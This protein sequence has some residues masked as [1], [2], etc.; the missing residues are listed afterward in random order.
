MKEYKHDSFGRVCTL[1]GKPILRARHLLTNKLQ[2]RLV[3]GTGR[4]FFKD[5]SKY[6]LV[7]CGSC[8]ECVA[9]TQD[10]YVQRAQS[11]SLYNY[12]FF[13]TLTFDDAHLPRLRVKV[14]PVAEESCECLCPYPSIDLEY[15]PEVTS[16]YSDNV[17]DTVCDNFDSRDH[18]GDEFLDLSDFPVEPDPSDMTGYRNRVV[19]RDLS[20]ILEE[21][22]I[23]DD[24][25]DMTSIPYADVHLL[26]LLMKRIRDN[27]MTLPEFAGRSMRYLA[28]SELGKERGR[29]H[30][31]IK[32]SVSKLASDFKNGSV[33]P[34]ARRSLINPG[35][36]ENME[37]ILFEKFQEYWA[38][39]VG[40][41]KNP[42]Y[43]RLFTYRQKYKNG[44]LFRNFDCHFVDPENARK[45]AGTDD[46]SYY[47]TKYAL[48]DSSW[49]QKR[50]AFLFARFS[51]KEAREYYQTIRSRLLISKGYG[52]NVTFVRPASGGRRSMI[53][54]REL[55]ERIKANSTIDAGKSPLPVFIDPNGKHKTL[56]GYY[57]SRPECYDYPQFFAI[58]ISVTQD[59]LDEQ[60]SRLNDIARIDYRLQDYA[61]KKRI[62][63]SRF[64][65]ED[66][67][68]LADLYTP[69]DN[70]V[71]K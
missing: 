64:G 47:V 9:M 66:A 16:R 1:Q 55:C 8:S 24:F 65:F 36:I 28:V 41:R 31:H 54:C 30:F 60:M 50:K 43:E 52:L 10:G 12:D 40:T 11:E 34:I 69:I 29:P 21:E 46:I 61:R 3:L 7:P 44:Q 45:S 57:R 23:L 6:M 25:G 51:P 67:L 13:I 5:E 58:N 35:I 39:N 32:F 26:Q 14:P 19:I 17:L 56:T 62:R 38:I 70:P 20:S 33:A 22:V 71:Y 18:V 63:E 37:K 2:D 59:M 15:I 4:S 42:K 53:P 68:A 48:K 49:E 27:V